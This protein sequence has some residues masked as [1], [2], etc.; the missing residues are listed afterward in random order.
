MSQSEDEQDDSN[1]IYDQLRSIRPFTVDQLFNIF[2]GIAYN[3][4]ATSRDDYDRI[5]TIEHDQNLYDNLVDYEK[6]KNML[7]KLKHDIKHARLEANDNMGKIWTF[8][9][10]NLRKIGLCQQGNIA[11]INHKYEQAFIDLNRLNRLDS[12][13]DELIDKIGKEYIYL[14]Y[15]SQVKLL[16][17]KA[18]LSG[19]YL[20]EGEEEKAAKFK[21]LICTLIDF[22]RHLGD[23]KSDFLKLCHKW[24]RTLIQRFLENENTDD[25]KFVIAQLCKGPAGTS[26]WSA[27]LL[28]CK[29][30]EK[31]CRFETAPEYI[32]Y[33]CTLL[34]ELF[35]QLK[36]RI[37]KVSLAEENS[38]NSH[39]NHDELS[40]RSWALVDPRFVEIENINPFS[41]AG[42][43]F[44]EADVINYCSR[45]P[46]VQLF[47][48]YVQKCLGSEKL[49]SEP[50]SVCE[51]LM[52]EFL[53]LGT[54]IMKTYQL[55]LEAF[56]KI[57][58]GN[59]TDYLSHQIRVVVIILSEQ[60]AE[61]KRRLREPQSVLILRLQ[62][63]YDNFIL[64]SILIILELRQNG[65]WRHLSLRHDQESVIQP[66]DILNSWSTSSIRSAL[67]RVTGYIT[68]QSQDENSE[69]TKTDP[70]RNSPLTHEFSLEWF[71]EVSEPMLWHI[72][73]QFY[74]NAF[75]SSC[76][77]H[78]DSYWLSK[79]KEKSV[80]YLFIDKIRYSSNC[81]RNFMLNS[82]TNMLLSRTRK[83]SNLIT[84]IATEIFNLSFK[85]EFTKDKTVDEGIKCLRRSAERFPHLI[86]LYVKFIDEEGVDRRVVELIRECSLNGWMCEP[87]MLDMIARWLIEHPLNSARNQVARLIITKLIINSPETRPTASL[88]E[89]QSNQS[90]MI[91]TTA[92]FVDLNL[93]RKFTLM[94]Y[95]ASIRQLEISN[96]QDLDI[97]LGGLVE[98]ALRSRYDDS[99]SNSQ[100]DLKLT[101]ELASDTSYR[102]FYTWMWH[103]MINFRL[104]ILN[105]HDTDWN[106]VKSPSGTS[107]SIKNTVLLN[108]SFHPSP[109]IQDVE[110]QMI[111]QGV[112]NR[113]PLASFIYLSMTDI[114]WQDDGFEACLELLNLMASSG[115][116]T[117]SLMAM[118]YIV[119]C[120]L[121]DLSNLADTRTCQD[122]F[123]SVITSNLEPTYIASL[124]SYQMDNLKQYRQ[125]QL[126]EFYIKALLGVASK[127]QLS[128][129][130]FFGDESCL[131]RIAL[132]LDYIVKFNFTTQRSD[133][134]HKFYET[135]YALH[136]FRSTSGWLWMFSTGSNSN[137]SGRE[138][139]TILHYLTQKFKHLHWL[140]WVTTECDALRLDKIW[141]DLV[142][143]LS[144]NETASLES[145]MK[146]VC[147][148]HNPVL[149][150]SLLPINS[151]MKQIFDL[152]ET[153]LNH[154][155]CPAVWY[156]FFLNYF[157]NSLN[158]VS[159]GTK[160]VSSEKLTLLLS[161]L[162]SL[163]DYHS[164]KRR[165][166]DGTPCKGSLAQ[167]YRAYKLWLQDGSLQGAYV[168]L[169]R[170]GSDYLVPLLKAIVES[171]SV[172]AF[173]P[174]IDLSIIHKQNADISGIWLG[175]SKMRFDHPKE[176]PDL[177]QEIAA[178]ALETPIMK[179]DL[180]DTQLSASALKPP[181]F[182]CLTNEEDD[183]RRSLPDLMP[184]QGDSMKFIEKNFLLVMKES[185]IFSSN[186]N[187][188]I[189]IRIELF[190]LIQ[191]LYTNK[192][193][194][195]IRSKACSDGPECSSP[196]KIKYELEEATID[197]RKSECIQDRKNQ[198][199]A[200]IN[201]LLL[202]PDQETIRS[203][204]RIEDS[205]KQLIKCGSEN[206]AIQCL[207]RWVKHKETYDY[208][209]GPYYPAN[210]L[211][212]VLL[213]LLSEA[214]NKDAFNTA[215][216]E[217]CL[218]HPGG[219]Q[220][221]SPHFSPSTCSE[222]CFLDLYRQIGE[223]QLELGSM[224]TFVLLSKFDL[225]SWINKVDE[226]KRHKL[227]VATCSAL[228]KLGKQPDENYTLTF[229]QYRHHIQTELKFSGSTGRINNIVLVFS[230]FLR[231]MDDQSLAPSL[232][233]DLL[234]AI[235]LERQMNKDVNDR[236]S[237]QDL[238][239][240]MINFARDI[241][242][243]GSQTKTTTSSLENVLRYAE[244]QRV[245]D[246]H[247]INNLLVELIG[248]LNS[249]NELIDVTLIEFY[250]D[251]L[252][253]FSVVMLSLTF[254]WLKTTADEYPDNHDLTWKQFMD[255]WY[256]WVFLT[257]NCQNV[258]KCSYS[259]ISNCFIAAVRYM[260]N[261]IPTNTQLI[262]RSVLSTLTNNVIKTEHVL[263]LELYILQNNM[264][265]LPWS[266][267][268]LLPEDFRFLA[269]LSQQDRY[270]VSDLVSHILIQMDMKETL[271][272]IR[273]ENEDDLP[274][275]V[276]YLAISIVLQSSHLKGMRLAGDFFHLIPKEKVSTIESLI[277][278]RMEFAN[279]E[280][281][282][283]NKLLVNL[284]RLMCIKLDTSSN[285]QSST[286]PDILGRSTIYAHFISSYLTNLISKH[287]SVVTKN[288]DY[289]MAVV[290]HS[291]YDL[292][293]LVSPDVDISQKIFTYENLL[294]CCSSSLIT[295]SAR[296]VIADC[297]IESEWLK[298]KPIVMMEILRV[299]GLI[300][301]DP[302]VLIHM[303][304][305]IA[306]LYLNTD[307][308]YEK[309]WK[310][311]SLKVLPSDLYLETC[312][313]M[314]ASLAMLIY[315]EALS[316]SGQ[317]FSR[318]DNHSCSSSGESLSQNN[319]V[320]TCFLHWIA[321]LSTSATATETIND[322]KLTFIRL[323]ICWLRF[324][325]LFEADLHQFLNLTMHMKNEAGSEETQPTTLRHHRALLDFIERLVTIHDTKNSSGLWS[326]LKSTRS[327]ASLKI[328]LVALAV[329]CFLADR[330]LCCLW[331][332]NF[333][334]LDEE[335]KS[336]SGRSSGP[337]HLMSVRGEMY[338][339]RKSCLAKLD[340]T[341][342]SR[343][344]A[345]SLQF[346]EALI[347]SINKNDIVQY[348]EGVQLIVT[349]VKTHASGSSSEGDLVCI[350]KILPT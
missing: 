322:Q 143:F 156:N 185:S 127:K 193:K 147:P 286:D 266:N 192:K 81:D 82:I 196:A 276:E 200:V 245:F 184:D 29:P 34:S 249:K 183:L 80:V 45:I 294:E 221:F 254:V 40:S 88:D 9:Q 69:T 138:F 211:L 28:E 174:Y 158:G 224:A 162:D 51:N 285:P 229:D 131:E 246:Y 95:E 16:R 86:S 13:F 350:N 66:S 259:L 332:G 148:Q 270:N 215:L 279:L 37:K 218:V 337:Q 159:V 3:P 119:I 195:Y 120:H 289:I 43:T 144:T 1:S 255:L 65:I 50:K 250:R 216:V 47:K 209:N 301:N 122:Y 94:L 252:E 135:S 295:E 181:T 78:N 85:Q 129:S 56:D 110:C 70:I 253:Q 336:K 319:I 247:S 304:E 241:D 273:G 281:S 31:T 220:V 202:M 92:R 4:K 307:G 338:R 98:T 175:I 60:W 340:A 96:S 309:V 179:L 262:L 72:L 187:E 260:I 27:D 106:D 67:N 99:N 74:H 205:M 89:T 227:V 346:I 328:G 112:K 10:E 228:G 58:F 274:E 84:F 161:R 191:Q 297:F 134:V 213:E 292:K 208:L 102:T 217:I 234:D 231:I 116:L 23:T 300:I 146:K 101:L 35:A 26:L 296:L 280:H 334:S 130:W 42:N 306:S 204:T 90:D 100:P 75:I 133:I 349:Y 108:D 59:L 315:F 123:T 314:N 313:R 113:N 305:S 91:R 176:E 333:S 114:T 152:V 121:N 171:S 61:F 207:S 36:I 206:D 105:Q 182:L 287:P 268:R 201:D 6:L 308:H 261:K 342:K 166:S 154:P 145:A 226:K 257:K 240:S 331:T 329:A 169:D 164:Y 103:L 163:H 125:L 64:R 290:Q 149:L 167:L 168:D 55:G 283:T 265:S 73:W 115:Y 251:Y 49:A 212:K 63:E 160:I 291:L 186:I 321:Q 239:N 83:S 263:Y 165:N 324:L 326:Y 310:S 132:L 141:E 214:S 142:N 258:E 233:A 12:H 335:M 25:C 107:R 190:G 235:G 97:G 39:A 345:D 238:N 278:P 339:L 275:A 117:P 219:V 288:R 248:H 223:S 48:D 57:Q 41:M 71:K 271:N 22:I 17:I 277:V 256:N 33:C 320:W 327:E 8:K 197:D 128:S 79:F 172:D 318:E 272:R 157:A 210:H 225:N 194:E 230:Q 104:H 242:L 303:V 93:R 87:D 203:T 137:S 199:K 317:A 21:S 5:Y 124:I 139:M 284:L 173:I 77:Y 177:T 19:I 178:S 244:S 330:S 109:S 153:N 323:Q 243:S 282:Q 118:K 264:R 236:E 14:S 299:I 24:L 237:N 155:L 232:W 269:L 298:D 20:M 76:E 189:R 180:D 52:L 316:C 46:A 170:L 302:C 151:W 293:P 126:S 38:E 188:V 32:A 62:V 140:R 136:D 198:C 267:F 347:E 15:E 54:V 111:S 2:P 44:S 341:R 344:Y 325:G 150:K 311:F 343:Q 68:S 7:N 312:V 53:T 11:E 348:S 222:D 18:Q 30:F